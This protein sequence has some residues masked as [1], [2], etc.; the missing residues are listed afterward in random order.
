[1]RKLIRTLVFFLALL[2]PLSVLAGRIPTPKSA[3]SI[4]SGFF[5]KYGKTHK[6]SLFG[7]VKISKVEIGQVRESARNQAQIEAYVNLASG[8]AAH[9]LVSIKKT[10]P[11]GWSVASWEMLEAR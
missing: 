9:V 3:Q 8:E 1:M 7:R 11:F 5:K 6:D 2:V 10:P 4:A